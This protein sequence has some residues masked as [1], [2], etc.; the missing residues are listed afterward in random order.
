MSGHADGFKNTTRKPIN[1]TTDPK[2]ENS[3]QGSSGQGVPGLEELLSVIEAIAATPI[4]RHPAIGDDIINKLKYTPLYAAYVALQPVMMKIFVSET[5][6]EARSP[7]KLANSGPETIPQLKPLETG[8][9]T[10]LRT[11]DTISKNIAKGEEVASG[12]RVLAE[13]G[14]ANRD[15]M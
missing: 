8:L 6:V 4:G 12:L 2:P 9:S 11:V 10:M 3:R 15:A 1:F 7:W 13:K 5:T 14:N